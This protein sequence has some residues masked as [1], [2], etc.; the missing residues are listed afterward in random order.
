MTLISA[1]VTFYMESIAGAWKLLIVTGAGT[2]GVL[3]LRWY[4]WR[5]NAWSEVSAMI[6]AFI[7]RSSLQT[8]MGPGQRQAHRLRLDHAH[9]GRHHDSRVARNDP[10]DGARIQETLVRS[11][12]VRAKH[13]R[14]AADRGIAPEVRTTTGRSVEFARLDLRLHSDLWSAVRRWQAAPE[15]NRLGPLMLGAGLLAGAV[16]YWDLSRRGWSSVVD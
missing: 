12:A 16:I 5:I 9:H 14:L 10:P 11:T 7:V 3:L 2:G 15:R 1:V 8:Y 13:C 4:W 6:S